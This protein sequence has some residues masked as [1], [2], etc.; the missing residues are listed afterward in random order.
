MKINDPSLVAKRIILQR[1]WDKE[2][3]TYIS[4]KANELSKH[5]DKEILQELIKEA[6]NEGK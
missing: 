4:T 2:Y 6:K 3:E 1:K 5:I